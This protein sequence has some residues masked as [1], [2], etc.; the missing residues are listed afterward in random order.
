MVGCFGILADLGFRIDTYVE[1]NCTTRFDPK[2]FLCW[3]SLSKSYRWRLLRNMGED[4][5]AD[6]NMII[7]LIIFIDLCY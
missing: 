7:I 1:A 4:K 3:S 2:G 6:C 5:M